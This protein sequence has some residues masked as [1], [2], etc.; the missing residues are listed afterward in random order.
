MKNKYM[1]FITGSQD[2]YGEDTLIQVDKDSR[3]IASYLNAEK[4]NPITIKYYGTAKN[5]DQ[6]VEAVDKVN[7]EKDCIGIIVWCHT[8][9][10]AKMWINGLKKLNKPLLHLHTQINNK[11]PYETIDMDFMNLNQAAHGD[12][13][14]G[15]VCARLG[16]KRKVV[17]GYYKDKNVL[18]EIYSFARLCAVRD[19]AEKVKVCRFGDNMR[20]VAV[21]DGDKVSAQIQ[22]GWSVDYYGI[23]DLVEY[24]AKVSDKEI[25][26]KF[27]EYVKVYTLNTDN[28]DSVK[29]QIK[30]EIAIEKFL[31]DHNANAFTTNF[32]DLHGLKQLPGMAVQNLMKKGVGFGAEGDWKTSAMTACLK[33]GAT[34]KAGA[35]VFMEDY[36]YDYSAGNELELG[37]HMLEVDPSIA[38]NKPKIE[39]HP[40]G[41][42]GKE[43]PARLVFDSAT[44]KGISVSIVDMGTNF[45]MIVQKLEMV[46]A[47][48]KMPKLPVSGVMWKLLPDFKTA[49]RRWIEE[50]GAHHMTLTNQYTAEEMADLAK[51]WGIPC[52]IIG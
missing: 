20:N 41:I 8:F 16:L 25:E 39:V 34:G 29:E 1:Y 36:T 27:N 19:Y 18:D 33:Y 15:H 44:G 40:L 30:Y 31:K 42:G 23:G 10:P 21:T 45:K 37:S 26:D 7:F 52:V 43:P 46:K 6:I 11:L 35:S 49:T 9:S 3:E 50:G 17:S 12:R 47:P 38:S 2:L 14:F 51:L 13:E 5:N 24:V 4:E 48:E 22:F 32:E 28:V